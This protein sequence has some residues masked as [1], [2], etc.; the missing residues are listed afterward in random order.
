VRSRD[1]FLCLSSLSTHQAD[2][3]CIADVV[4]RLLQTTPMRIQPQTEGKYGL[5]QALRPFWQCDL[6]NRFFYTLLNSADSKNGN[7]EVRGWKGKEWRQRDHF[8]LLPD[9]TTPL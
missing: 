4:H 1:L 3:L 7:V 6:W 9:V 5:A 2:L 8:Y